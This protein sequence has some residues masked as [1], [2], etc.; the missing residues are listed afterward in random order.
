[1]VKTIIEDHWDINVCNIEKIK[2]LY[3]DVYVINEKYV[4]KVTDINSSKKQKIINLC[5][6][7]AYEKKLPIDKPR[8]LAKSVTVE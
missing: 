2:A 8:N 1:M 7:K 3:S 6:N 4:L 5:I